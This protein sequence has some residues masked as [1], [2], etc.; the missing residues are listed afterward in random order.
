MDSKGSGDVP[1]VGVHPCSRA[2]TPPPSLGIL[3][4]FSRPLL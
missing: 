4:T 2:E 1:C 3:C